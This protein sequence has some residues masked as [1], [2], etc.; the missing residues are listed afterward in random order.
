MKQTLTFTPSLFKS[1]ASKINVDIWD[2]CVD[3]YDNKEFLKSFHLLLDYINPELQKKYGNESRTEYVIPHGAITITL[4]YD[5]DQFSATAPFMN[6]PE[7]NKIPMMRQTASLNFN[8]LYMAQIELK[9]NDLHFEYTCPAGLIQPYKL[10]YVFKDICSVGDKY[11]AEFA[12]KFN[13]SLIKEPQIKPYDAQTIEKVYNIVQ[14]SCNECNEAVKYFENERK[15]GFAWNII[16]CTLLK[17]LYYAHP[18]GQLLYDISKVLYDMDKE[19]VPLIEANALGKK[20]VEQIQAMPKD[21]LAKY[22]YHEESFVSSKNRSSLKNI[23]DNFKNS[24]EKIVNYYDQA[25]YMS[26]CVMITYQFYNMYFYNDVQD[27]VNALVV[28]AFEASS[29]QTWEKAAEPLYKAMNSIM[30]GDLTPLKGKTKSGGFLSSI[31]GKKK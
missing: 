15:Y 11:V 19:E 12:S 20:M 7:N 23:Q 9:D 3:A 8:N 21:E 24:Y 26:V 18:K 17:L 10:Y 31:F 16:D 29:G 13:A 27:D 4:K 1:T 6:L 2:Q 14:Q 5:D 30:N 28:S 22:L 25:D